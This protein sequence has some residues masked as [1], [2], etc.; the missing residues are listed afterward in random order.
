MRRHI[1]P[2]ILIA[3]VSGICFA[4]ALHGEF[5]WDD[6]H[7]VVRNQGIRDVRNIPRFFHPDYWRALFADYQGMPG[8]HYRPVPEATLAID[9][10]IWKHM[11]A[12]RPVDPEIPDFF[13]QPFG[14]HLTSVVVHTANSILLYLVGLRLFG[15]RRGALFCALLFAAHPIHVEA[16]AWAKA[17][18]TLLAMFFMLLTMLLYTR[19]AHS[20]GRPRHTCL[21]ILSIVALG[22]ATMSKASAVMLPPM[23]ALYLWCVVPRNQ[24]R[25]ALYGLLPLVGVTMAFYALH[26]AVP[27]HILS[28]TATPVQ[29]LF[30]GVSAFGFYARLLTVPIGMCVHHYFSLL[31]PP[32]LPA[33][34]WVVAFVAGMAIALWRSRLAFFALAWILIASAP[35]WA[36]TLVGRAIGEQRA[37]APSVGF[38]VLIALL[39]SRLPVLARSADTRRSLEKLGTALLVMIVVAYSGITI[40]RNADWRTKVSLWYDTVRKNPQSDQA[41]GALARAYIDIGQNETALEHLKALLELMPEDTWALDQAGVLC[42]EMGRYSEAILYYQRLLTLVP[43]NA[44]GHLGLGIAYAKSNRRAE[45]LASFEE[46]RR[47]A[48]LDSDI[49]Y[50]LGV[51]H[52]GGDEPEKAIAPLEEAVRLNPMNVP[53]WQMLGGTQ[54]Y[55]GAYQQAIAAYD[56]I[57]AIQ[58]DDPP[59]RLSAA[60]CHEALGETAEAIRHYRRCAQVPG[61]MGEYAQERIRILTQAPPE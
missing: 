5:F 15:S 43:S 30:A 49:N 27:K 40:A 6:V 1:G 61:G 45:A 35:T 55:L 19:W 59:T 60:R 56:A 50:N 58:P 36:L 25:R 37:Y 33:V 52:S 21:Y 8:R 57:L 24:L 53:A 16:V 17:R 32:F 26:D 48:P 22:L 9:Y 13:V 54:E 7:I 14:F 46:A 18:S 23:L 47:L 44:A 34:P 39:L 20:A 31:D 4:N 28:A 29:H 38:C 41:H 10:A 11:P 51:F 2:I 42:D 3:V 12:K